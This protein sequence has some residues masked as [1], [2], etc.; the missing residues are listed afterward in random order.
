MECLLSFFYNRPINKAS[1]MESRDDDL[2]L[3]EFSQYDNITN[4]YILDYVLNWYIQ[5]LKLIWET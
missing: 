1:G 2:D 3:A 5:T 4:P